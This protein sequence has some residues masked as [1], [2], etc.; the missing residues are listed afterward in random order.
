[1]SEVKVHANIPHTE[2]TNHFRLLPFMLS[3]IM[4][5]KEKLTDAE[6]KCG[7]QAKK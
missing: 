5:S 7:A 6:F 1:M 4:L 2:M 3:K